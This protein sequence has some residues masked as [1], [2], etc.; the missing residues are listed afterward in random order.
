MILQTITKEYLRFPI[1]LY[2]AVL[3]FIVA[4]LAFY[5]I[6]GETAQSAIYSD[7][8]LSFTDSE[9][10]GTW[11]VTD[12]SQPTSV[13]IAPGNNH[14]YAA[15][16][17][18]N[19]IILFSR[20]S[21]TG[22]LQQIQT[23][24]DNENGIDGLSQVHDLAISPDGFHLYAAGEADDS[25]AVFSRD[26]ESGLLTFIEK[27][28]NG[29][30]GVHGL[31]GVSGIL[32]SPDGKN[33]YAAGTHDD[34]IVVFDRHAYL[35]TL[36]FK[37]SITDGV[38]GVDGLDGSRG[39][40]MSTDNRFLYSTGIVDD[41]VT[42]FSRDTSTGV[43]SYVEMKK[44]GSGGITSLNG[45]NDLLVSPDGQYLYV[46]APNDDAV[47]V[48]N[49]STSTGALT[50]VEAQVDGILGVDGL[51]GAFGI[52]ASPDNLHV[53]V[54]GLNDNA[55]S[56]FRR[57]S[58]DGSLFYVEV[59]IDGTG[60]V[61]GMQFPVST[62]VTSDGT[63]IYVAGKG[64]DSIVEFT[65]SSS[66]GTITYSGKSTNNFQGVDG[67]EGV[68]DVE[69]LSNEKVLYTAGYDEDTIGIFSASATTSILTYN[70][71]IND[72]QSASNYLDG[73]YTLESSSNSKFLYAGSS[74]G[75]SISAF[76][77]NSATGTLAYIEHHIDNT[78]GV[79]GLDGVRDIRISP[80]GSHLYTAG[81]EDNAI[82]VFSIDG[83]SGQLS[84]IRSYVNGLDGVHG[85]QGATAIAISPDGKHLY[86]AGW[87]GNSVAAFSID[88]TTGLLNYLGYISNEQHGITSLWSPSDLEVTPDGKHLYI[89]AATSDSLTA[90]KRE[91][92]TGS[93]SLIGFLKD[94]T[95]G[96]DGLDWASSLEITSDGKHIVVTAAIDDMI[97]VFRRNP[98]TGSFTLRGYFKDGQLGVDGLEGA[99]SVN[100]SAD[101]SSVYVA[102]KD[103]NMVSAFL[104]TKLSY[105]YTPYPTAVPTSTPTPSPVP[106][107]YPEFTIIPEDQFKVKEIKGNLSSVKVVHPNKKAKFI[108]KS[109]PT[110]MSFDA[111]IYETSFQI[112][113]DMDKSHCS[114]E[115]RNGTNLRCIDLKAFDYLG[116]PLSGID[117]L[118][119]ATLRATMTN[120]ELALI[121]GPEKAYLEAL[122]GRLRFEGFDKR[123]PGLEWIEIHSDQTLKRNI[124]GL[125]GASG[126]EISSDG[127]KV[128]VT[129]D[130]R[131][132]ISLFERNENTGTLTFIGSTI[133]EGGKDNSPVSLE[134]FHS[135]NGIYVSS[136]DSIVTA[137]HYGVAGGLSK[138]TE[139]IEGLE[140]TPGFAVAISEIPQVDRIAAVSDQG[141]LYLLTHSNQSDQLIHVFTVSP[142]PEGGILT[143]VSDLEASPDGKHIYVS[144][145]TP[146]AISVYALSEEKNFL[147][148]V[149][150]IEQF[151]TGVESIAL[152]PD[153]SYLYAAAKS[154]NRL[155]IF[156]RDSNTGALS[157]A[158]YIS[159]GLFTVKGLAGVSNISISS[160]GTNLYAASPSENTMT[161][162]KRDIQTGLLQFLGSVT[163][164]V[165]KVH[166][167]GS[168]SSVVVSPDGQH[169]YAIGKS[170]DAVVTFWRR[171]NGI[172][173]L[174]SVIR[175]QAEDNPQTLIV[176]APYM[177][178][179]GTYGL[180]WYPEPKID[181]SNLSTPNPSI[182]EPSIKEPSI[183]EPSIKEPSIE[184]PSVGA[185]QVTVRTLGLAALAGLLVLLITVRLLGTINKRSKD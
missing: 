183:K 85:I 158:G 34:Q 136:I 74:I 83:T 31:D 46:T 169:V 15:S 148:Y 171:S 180:N 3:G 69:L 44:D 5:M 77:I 53:Y 118:F 20:N 114:V 75:D 140:N 71:Q 97:T 116:E 7:F 76:S 142:R 51:D 29:I 153:G 167:L 147:T 135:G 66:T 151:L 139:V 13:V 178:R 112:T 146:G 102:G 164:E 130:L 122:A 106:T 79:E 172:I 132:S 96:I 86:C 173:G 88:D 36:T 14:V 100:I 113:M 16:S 6:P 63:H 35:G 163:D 124:S 110:E 168:I 47:T 57:S 22:R 42:V 119:P 38:A 181:T 101:D 117:F 162:F 105:S 58:L 61:D 17:G 111:P 21:F 26:T 160:D 157:L 137:Y 166:G 60:T 134:P 11:D 50:F 80:S 144:S 89:T 103:E 152:S 37:E 94:N 155:T 33:V 107:P 185:S 127:K 145:R 90:F 115:P 95:N 108:L 87:K 175:Q 48:F 65:R 54:V 123:R 182:K 177:R 55:I 64:E 170:D 45:A 59:S 56:T 32:V 91:P 39:L 73:V 161:V 28:K 159:D 138:S 40:S 72:S 143:E 141:N 68:T 156:L 93:L 121:G 8:T 150:K 120:Q 84:F 99:Y 1:G 78:A 12:L 2:I 9:K 125:S 176:K 131:P 174:Q 184:P 154:E 165:A 133:M 19:S 23:Y 104:G 10:D 128:F 67:L 62:D 92:S 149:G 98:S 43:L 30:F 27:H 129:S 41:A 25:V 82:G 81:F 24:T 4:F 179:T 109:P 49:I 52:V 126:V 18:S 70:G